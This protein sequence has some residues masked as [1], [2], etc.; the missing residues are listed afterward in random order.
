MITATDSIQQHAQAL[1]RRPDTPI[2][3]QNMVLLSSAKR[4]CCF[5]VTIQILL[6]LIMVQ[7]GRRCVRQFFIMTHT[8]HS[9]RNIL[10]LVFS[11]ILQGSHDMNEKN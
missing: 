1:L 8:T 10:R 4:V 11:E 3:T 5:K 7:I 9:L 2:F 6:A